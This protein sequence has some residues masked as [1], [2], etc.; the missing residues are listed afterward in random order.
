MEDVLEVYKLPY[1][2][3]RPV[4]CFDETSRQLIEETQAPRPVQPGQAAL[5]DFEYIRNGVANLFM[6]FEPLANRREVILTAK[7][8]MQDFAR[9]LWYLAM[10]M[11]PLAEKIIVV[12]DNLNTHTLASLYATFDPETARQLCERF[13]IHYTPKHG[14]WLNMAEVEIGVMSRQCL[15]RRI[16]T[17]EK[18]NEE[19]QA[20][21]V[22]RN[23]N[24]ATVRWQF[25]TADA[26]IK[27]QHLYPQI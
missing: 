19:V 22:Q 26:R 5:H 16:P 21:V 25:T 6:I 4:V 14:S 27:L 20:W 17:M 24:K 12:M 3:K 15:D 1:D 2:E 13:E 18:M 9:C 10:V 7:R 11:Y 8:T 23:N